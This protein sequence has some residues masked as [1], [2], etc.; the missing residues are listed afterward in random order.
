[1]KQFI[2]QIDYA[3]DKIAVTLYYTNNLKNDSVSEGYLKTSSPPS[4]LKPKKIS[5]VS[6]GTF[7]KWSPRME[8]TRTITITLPNTIHACKRKNL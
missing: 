3:K 5:P 7:R 8:W 6:H 2:K 1:V 4:S